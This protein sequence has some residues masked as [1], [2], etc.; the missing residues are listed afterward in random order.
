M[1]RTVR[2][3]AIRDL[4]PPGPHE[5]LPEITPRPSR[6]PERAILVAW[7]VVV[8]LGTAA[9]L[10][11]GGVAEVRAGEMAARHA[12]AEGWANAHPE[13]DPYPWSTR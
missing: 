9:A 6:L 10:C 13:S 1:S 12:Q 8:L 5:D 7:A 4:L 3:P 11:A 2:V